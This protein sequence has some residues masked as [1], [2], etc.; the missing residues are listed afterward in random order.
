MLRSDYLVLSHSKSFIE[1]ELICLVL[2][3]PFLAAYLQEY[4][5]GNTVRI[6]SCMLGSLHSTHFQ[7]CNRHQFYILMQPKKFL[8]IVFK[9][10]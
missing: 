5:R 6:W 9:K 10:L 4:R 3:L 1:L 7:L 8:K 2:H